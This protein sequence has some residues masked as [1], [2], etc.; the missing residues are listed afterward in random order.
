MWHIGRLGNTEAI[1]GAANT[2]KSSISSHERQALVNLGIAAA[3]IDRLPSDEL[4]A[5]MV[6]KAK[7]KSNSI[8]D[9]RLYFTKMDALGVPLDHETLN[10]IRGTSDA[11]LGGLEKRRRADKPGMEISDADA[12]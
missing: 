2:A 3:D 9:D 8:K 6:R 10:R 7:E 11:E 5:L 4:A 1:L 12:K